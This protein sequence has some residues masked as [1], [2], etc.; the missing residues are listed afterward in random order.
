M[1]WRVLGFATALAVLPTVLFGLAPAFRATRVEPAALLQSGSR[2]MTGGRERFTLRRV[3]V[4]SQVALSVV[5][6]MGALLFTRSLRNLTTLNIGF[7]QNGILIAS[8]HFTRLHVPEDQCTEYKRA[9]IRPIKA[10]PGVESA[11]NAMLVPFGGNTWNDD[12]ITEGSDKDQGV[13]WLN[14]LGPGY[15][16]AIGT[17]LLAGRDFNN[18]DTATSVK[19][20]VV[21]E[22]FVKKILN[23]GDPLGKRFCI[24]EAPGKPRPL[25]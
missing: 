21:N 2:G 4:V 18:Q 9:L 19:V 16:Q 11:A 23:V 3:L 24:H 1:D 6:L 8:V 12:I 22:A 13:A 15:F 25:Y 17:P 20:A 7:Q 14:Y 5:L 10:I